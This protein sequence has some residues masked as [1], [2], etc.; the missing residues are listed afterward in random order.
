MFR[1]LECL[2]LMT[3]H[4]W[5]FHKHNILL[6]FVSLDSHSSIPDTC[7]GLLHLFSICPSSLS[8]VSILLDVFELDCELEKVGYLNFNCT[9]F[10]CRSLNTTLGTLSMGPSL[11]QLT[12]CIHSSTVLVA[13]SYEAL[14]F[15]DLRQTYTYP[16]LPTDLGFCIFQAAKLWTCCIIQPTI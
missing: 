3:N 14:Y 9:F 5:P 6:R 12:F 15:S 16:S 11:L 10:S 2:Q 1:H 8:D 7:S 4:F 13:N